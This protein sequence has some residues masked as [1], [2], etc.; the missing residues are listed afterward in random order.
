VRAV[1]VQ[2]PSV[3]RV[4]DQERDARPKCLGLVYECFQARVSA[5]TCARG[6]G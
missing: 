3:V 4:Y 6:K 5:K 2:R 1:R